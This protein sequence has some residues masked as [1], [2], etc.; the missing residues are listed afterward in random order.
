MTQPLNYTPKAIADLSAM[1][2][3]ARRTAP[4]TA[5]GID[6]LLGKLKQAEVFILPDFGTL[7]DRSKARPELPATAL[8]PPFPVVA[9]EYVA[10][11]N[12]WGDTF[13]TAS[14]CSR[15]I[16]LAWDYTDDLPPTM[17]GAMPPLP[18]GFVVASIAFYDEHQKWMPIAAAVHFEYEGGWMD[19]PGTGE[20]RD[21]MVAAG[22]ISKAQASARALPASPII[23]SPETLA[24]AT[25]T[26]GSERAREGILA[27]LMDE[28]NAYIDLA[29][30]LACRNVSTRA[31]P[32][33]AVLN[34]Q[35]VRKGKP[36]LYGFHVLELAGADF[37]GD[38]SGEGDRNAP[39]AHLRRGHI[40]RLSAE[41]I[42]W[43]NQTMVRGRGFVDKV[44]A[45]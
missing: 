4:M 24:M 6:Y 3:E 26:S 39:R 41:R 30:A 19:H 10:Q 36:P 42:T 18:R 17:I 2:I 45:A 29:C 8:R 7:L 16:A 31:H 22:R 32:A 33:P 21:L 38:G 37:G 35:R 34:K 20:F 13:Y 1:A 25:L 15:R 5:I 28:V 23:V 12:E 27:D 44:Y 14:P 40:R 43:V 11:G 9:L